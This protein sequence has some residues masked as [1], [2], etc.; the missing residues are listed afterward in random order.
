MS[1]PRC[2]LGPALEV[3]PGGSDLGHYGPG[4]GGP[5]PREP[6]STLAEWPG[7]RDVTEGSAAGSGHRAADDRRTS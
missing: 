6:G 2:L 3:L 7:M 1:A 4:P 5:F